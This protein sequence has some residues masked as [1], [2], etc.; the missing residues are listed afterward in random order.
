MFSISCP[1]VRFF[2]N[3]VQFLPKSSQTI[4][5]LAMQRQNPSLPLFFYAKKSKNKKLYENIK[6]TKIIRKQRCLYSCLIISISREMFLYFLNK[7]G[8][9]QSEYECMEYKK[10]ITRILRAKKCIF[11][12]AFRLL[13]NLFVFNEDSPS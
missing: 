10:I 7:Y 4:V 3:P 11:L 9:V 12:H 8:K 1:H 13:I 5:A 2:E 6:I